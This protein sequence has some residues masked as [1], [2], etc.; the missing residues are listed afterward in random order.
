ME[1]D[2]TW[3]INPNEVSHACVKI[4][5]LENLNI[6]FETSVPLSLFHSFE[7]NSLC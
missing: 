1:R 6:F 7:S 2:T 5:Y 3:L 4:A